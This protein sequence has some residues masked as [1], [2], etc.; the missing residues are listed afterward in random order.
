MY[1][2]YLPSVILQKTRDEYYIKRFR[3]SEKHKMTRRSSSSTDFECNNHMTGLG[4]A[5]LALFI[6]ENVENELGP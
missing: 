4:A 1:I 3:F 5:S 6:R 2:T